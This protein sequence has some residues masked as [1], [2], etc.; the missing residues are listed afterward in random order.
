[1]SCC[2]AASL[3]SLCCPWF[4]ITAKPGLAWFLIPSWWWRL[5]GDLLLSFKVNFPCL[6][7]NFSKN[8]SYLGLLLLRDFIF[9]YFK[10]M[11]DMYVTLSHCKVRPPQKTAPCSKLCY[12][13][14][15]FPTVSPV[16]ERGADIE[17]DWA[18]I[19]YN[20]YLHWSQTSE[21]Q[22]SCVLC[23]G[24]ASCREWTDRIG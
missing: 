23:A 17:W 9:T 7:H 18:L 22:P 16:S 5:L 11:R 10:N 24:W 21:W 15:L 6:E 4:L 3:A 2:Q 1:M 14:H 8:W 20:H 19:I 13:T 12:L